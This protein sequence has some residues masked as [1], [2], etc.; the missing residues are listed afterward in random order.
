MSYERTGVPIM[1][2]VIMFHNEGLFEINLKS[3]LS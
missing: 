1:S 3:L 2:N